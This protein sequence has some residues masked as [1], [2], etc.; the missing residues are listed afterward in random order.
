[1]N[2]FSILYTAISS[3]HLMIG[4]L[5]SSGIQLDIIKWVVSVII[6]SCEQGS[7]SAPGPIAIANKLNNMFFNYPQILNLWYGFLWPSM[8]GDG[9]Y[10]LWSDNAINAE[11]QIA[12][13]AIINNW[14]R[15][16]DDKLKL[17]AFLDWKV[18]NLWCRN[19]STERNW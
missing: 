19:L 3:L 2:H 16:C 7:V 18:L 4:A 14:P 15:R 10:K 9:P 12:V 8:G 5:I 6:S 11:R 13:H 1:M 17:V